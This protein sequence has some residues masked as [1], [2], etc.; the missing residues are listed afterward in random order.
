M[1]QLLRSVWS[2]EDGQDL[3]EYTLLISFV[4]FITA[5]VMSIGGNSIKGIV[6]TSNSQIAEGNRIAAGS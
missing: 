2:D 4:V 5:G 1:H 3:I 6:N